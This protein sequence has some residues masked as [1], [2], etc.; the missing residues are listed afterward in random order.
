VKPAAAPLAA[1]LVT[2]LALTFSG[3]AGCAPAERPST[4]PIFIAAEA[5]YLTAGALERLAKAAPPSPLAGSSQD[6]AD[7]AE[8]VR[9]AALED[10]DRWLL[11]TAHAELRP[12]LALQHFDCALG[13]RLGSAQTPALDRMAAKAFHYVQ[14]VVQ[15]AAMRQ[16]AAGAARALPAADPGRRA[17]Q[18]LTPAAPRSVS[19]PSAAAA[20]G[21][22]YADL[23][24]VIQPDR[25]AA[26]RRIGDE[27][28]VSRL[29]CAMNYP[30]G[31]SAGGTLG[32]AVMAEIAATPEFHAEAIEARRELEAARATGRINPGCAAERA[33]LAQTA[34]AALSTSR[35]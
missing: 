28:G 13:V 34:P 33:A 12:P 14:A 20:T 29:V 7:R 19:Y 8:S 17:C 25:A 31:V 32:R 15:L 35:P 4:Q 18:V 30:S 2:P 6:R 27:I 5:G 26:V 24:A 22:A 1:A 9:L 16:A 3:L 21:A 10:S 23:L 11:A